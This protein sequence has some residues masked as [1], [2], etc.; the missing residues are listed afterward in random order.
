[1]HKS[2][3]GVFKRA[4]PMSIDLQL[5]IFMCC[6]HEVQVSSGGWGC[7]NE[8]GKKKKKKKKK[9][10]LHGSVLKPCSPTMKREPYD[11]S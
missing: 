3:E 2:R 5:N 1:M 8:K 6:D 7:P 4:P 9:K 11:L 10:K